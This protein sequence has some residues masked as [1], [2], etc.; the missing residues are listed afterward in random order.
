M[1][2]GLEIFP[3]QIADHAR[4]SGKVHAR[5]ELTWRRPAAP[6]K[7]VPHCA[8]P[9]GK[10]RRPAAVN[11][12][13]M[14]FPNDFVRLRY[15]AR[16][17][18]HRFP[19][20]AKVRRPRRAAALGGRHGFQIRSGH[21]RSAPPPRGSRHLRLRPARASHRRRSRGRDGAALRLANRGVMARLASGSGRRPQ[22]HRASVCGA[23]GRGPHRRA[24]LSAVH[25]RTQK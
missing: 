20:V 6:G 14:S 22:R 10:N 1:K 5:C 25:V 13:L 4:P 23:R 19:K 3:L 2:F 18:R 11:R 17:P 16:A 9:V 24:G 12:D 21:P 15:R 8:V 7:R